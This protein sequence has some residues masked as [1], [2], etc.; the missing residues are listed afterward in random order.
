[1]HPGHRT[2]LSAWLGLGLLSVIAAQPTF[3]QSAPNQSTFEQK[4]RPIPQALQGGHQGL[5]TL[6]APARPEPSSS[7]RPA[8]TSERAPAVGTRSGDQH[9]SVPA[10]RPK[11]ASAA[12]LPGC[13]AQSEADKAEKPMVGFKV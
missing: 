3:G 9:A 8:S 4:L 1:M 13:P 10:N 2:F 12:A 6:G 7:Y 11:A 5:P